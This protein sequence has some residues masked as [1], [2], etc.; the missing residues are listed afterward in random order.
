M[1]LRFGPRF[2]PRTR[3][4]KQPS[5]RRRLCTRKKVHKY[6][7]L[8][9]TLVS[10]TFDDGRRSNR[11]SAVFTLKEKK[12][13][14]KNWPNVLWQCTLAAFNV[15][16]RTYGW[17]TFAVFLARSWESLRFGVSAILL[18]ELWKVC[19]LR[20]RCSPPLL[21]NLKHVA[22]GW[23]CLHCICHLLK[24]ML[25]WGKII[26]RNNCSHGETTNLHERATN[27]R[28]LHY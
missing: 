20:A 10:P 16:A 7:R 4:R 22:R 9:Y 8:R 25:G 6:P 11:H 19:N 18:Q 17:K 15:G 2:W 28:V 3:H 24:R 21:C 1:S 26:K 13:C 14:P 27:N 23:H 5:T 12:K